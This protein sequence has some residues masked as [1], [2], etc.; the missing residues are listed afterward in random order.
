MYM[1]VIV[2][3]DVHCTHVCSVLFIISLT[4]QN[5]FFSMFTFCAYYIPWTCKPLEKN[6]FE[7][8][9]ILQTWLVNKLNNL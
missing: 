4:Q 5:I 3:E 2:H 8:Q 9:K 6:N 1:Y 7:A